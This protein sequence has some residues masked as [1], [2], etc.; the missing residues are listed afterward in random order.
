MWE[1][2]NKKIAKSLYTKKK[3]RNNNLGWQKQ[4][5]RWERKEVWRWM[6][7]KGVPHAMAE[8]LKLQQQKWLRVLL[9]N[10]EIQYYWYWLSQVKSSIESIHTANLWDIWEETERKTHKEKE[11]LTLIWVDTR[12]D[13]E[14][15]YKQRRI[16]QKPEI[17]VRD[18]QETC[19]AI[20]SYKNLR[21]SIDFLHHKKEG[22]EST[23]FRE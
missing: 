7:G 12:A 6:E 22:H 20:R 23:F 3:K 5:S 10:G 2:N 21:E 13:T 17:E 4:M 16:Q 18:D 15:E 14:Q 11:P 9:K 8:C 1:G 19:K